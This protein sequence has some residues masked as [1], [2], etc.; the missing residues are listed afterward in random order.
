[1]YYFLFVLNIVGSCA[2]GK[3]REKTK[4]HFTIPKLDEGLLL[5]FLFFQYISFCVHV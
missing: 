4:L 1:M 2:R 5:N 3:K